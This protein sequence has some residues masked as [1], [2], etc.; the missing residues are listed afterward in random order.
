MAF[1]LFT[2]SRGGGI[3][4]KQWNNLKQ[5]GMA[6]A[7]MAVR[8]GE[9]R[10]QAE[11]SRQEQMRIQHG[12]KR[13]YNPNLFHWATWKCAADRLPWGSHKP[14]NGQNSANC[15]EAIQVGW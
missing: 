2:P 15:I 3:N 10:R 1:Q 9:S 4:Q 12:G 8:Q 5:K 14:E 13:D 11:Q 6:Q 7:V